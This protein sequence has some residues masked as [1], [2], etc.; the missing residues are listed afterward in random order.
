MKRQL[1][2]DIALALFMYKEKYPGANDDLE[3]IAK[4]VGIS[5]E[6]LK[7]FLKTPTGEIIDRKWRRGRL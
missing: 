1:V 4:A 6:E 2:E 5:L 3:S 7:E